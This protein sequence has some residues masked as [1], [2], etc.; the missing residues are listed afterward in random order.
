MAHGIIFSRPFPRGVAGVCKRC[1]DV[2]LS[3]VDVVNLLLVRGSVKCALVLRSQ[4]IEVGL[5]CIRNT[6]TTGYALCSGLRLNLRGCVAWR[7]RR[8]GFEK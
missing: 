6:Y 5:F 2:L 4:P 3:V 7:Q 8:R 1:C